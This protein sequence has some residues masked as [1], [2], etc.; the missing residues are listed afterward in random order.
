MNINLQKWTSLLA[1]LEVGKFGGEIFTEEQLSDFESQYNIILPIEYKEYCQVFGTGQ[2]GEFMDIVCPSNRLIEVSNNLLNSIRSA[3]DDIPKSRANYL[4]ISIDAIMDLLDSAFV[5]GGY[6]DS[7]VLWDLRTY[8]EDDHSYDIYWAL[9]E[10]FMGDIYK[11]G[12]SFFEF[13]RDFCLGEK[14]FEVLPEEVYPMPEAICRTFR[15]HGS[16]KTY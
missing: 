5:F 6:D 9:S 13:I 1:E 8:Q 12:R 11:V 10:D 7:I 3:A 4:A 2:F 14:A 16:S 15:R